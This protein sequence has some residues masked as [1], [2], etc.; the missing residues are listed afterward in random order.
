MGTKYLYIFSI[1]LGSLTAALA[2]AIDY[3]PKMSFIV[4]A[5]ICRIAAGFQE[6]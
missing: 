6:T 5:V 4:F 1:G 2:I 3:M